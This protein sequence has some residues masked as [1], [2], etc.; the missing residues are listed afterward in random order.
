MV[1]FLFFVLIEK[2]RFI[3]MSFDKIEY[4]KHTGRVLHG[5]ML[6]ALSV[7]GDRAKSALGVLFEYA[8]D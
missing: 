3:D 7:I 5:F 4:I 2:F 6:R 8:T 1:F